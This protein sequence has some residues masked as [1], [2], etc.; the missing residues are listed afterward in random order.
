MFYRVVNTLGAKVS[1][2]GVAMVVV[3]IGFNCLVLKTILEQNKT[4]P[5]HSVHP[6]D[7]RISEPTLKGK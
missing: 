1:K 7:M 3:G 6:K 2:K 5:A 4:I